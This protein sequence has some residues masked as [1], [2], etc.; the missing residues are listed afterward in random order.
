[1]HER[2]DKALSTLR[3]ALME[4]GFEDPA[5]AFCFFDSD[6]SGLITPNE[7]TIGLRRLHLEHL[8]VPELGWALEGGGMRDDRVMFTEWMRNVGWGE[9]GGAVSAKSI[10]GQN[11]ALDAAMLVHRR[12]NRRVLAKAG[13]RAYQANAKA[14]A[15][16]RL[17]GQEARPA[18]SPSKLAGA[19]KRPGSTKAE[20]SKFD[21]GGTPI[22][23]D[24][25]S[26]PMGFSQPLTY[27]WTP[28]PTYR[29]PSYRDELHGTGKLA[30]SLGQCVVA[31]GA[32]N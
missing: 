12:T 16:A 22:R 9:F 18:V 23:I 29:H 27:H 24:E 13:K 17:L 26:L 11:R 15:R 32:T 31:C 4:I 7:L 14:A 21:A 30:S 2:G 25:F 1:M 10:V 19:A 28:D 3:E 8:S 5:Q 6:F 20:V